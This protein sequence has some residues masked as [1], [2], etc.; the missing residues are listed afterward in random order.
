MTDT[1]HAINRIAY[2][3]QRGQLATIAPDGSERVALGEPDATYQFPVWSPQSATIAVLRNTRHQGAVVL[4]DTA[5]Q[6]PGIEIYT[7]SQERPFYAS[8]RPD[9]RA[10]GLLATHREDGI[11]LHL[12]APGRAAQLLISGQPCFWDWAP[13]GDQ[14]LVHT[15]GAGD[16]GQI[17]FLTMD[18]L[19]L[20]NSLL[21][22]TP[23]GLFQA[24][25]FAPGGRFW[26]YGALDERNVARLVVSGTNGEQ[27]NTPHLGA[28]ALSWSPLR[29]LLAFSSPMIEA[30][31]WFGPLR[32]LHTET[33]IERVLV[34]EPV[35]AFFWSP[36]SQRIAYF[37]IGAIE[38]TRPSGSGYTNG[39]Y[40]NATLPPVYEQTREQRLI[41]KLGC[42][43]IS[44]GRQ[45]TLLEFAPVEL[46]TQQFLPFFDQYALSHRI[47][48]P[49]SSALLIPVLDHENPILTLAYVDGRP[50]RQIADG[51]IGFWSRS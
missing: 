49:D 28:V 30:R 29:N 7:S 33:G 6:A 46:F 16:A 8:W 4:Y 47:W 51:V 38:Q 37:T 45:Q 27:H 14:L 1:S 20:P 5:M 13:T 17:R 12:A 40:R 23:P 34:E 25:G 26:A 43:H 32:L 42:V 35:I 18:G 10:I 31:N 50:A 48:S 2:I 9:G 44:S 36:D 11:G 21:A 41:L 15:G 19:P 24:P 3:D 22:L 39:S